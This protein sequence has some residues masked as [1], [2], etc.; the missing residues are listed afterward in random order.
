VFA[1]LAGW[2]HRH[3]STLL[4]DA[5]TPRQVFMGYMVGFTGQFIAY[6]LLPHLID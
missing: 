4:L 3:R 5:H 6:S 1:I 2:H